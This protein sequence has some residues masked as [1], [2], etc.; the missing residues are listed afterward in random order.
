[1]GPILGVEGWF[2]S[3]RFVFWGSAHTIRAPQYSA[4]FGSTVLLYRPYIRRW[5]VISFKFIRICGLEALLTIC[6]HCNT[7]QH[8]ATH[9]N[10]LPNAATHCHALQHTATLSSGCTLFCWKSFRALFYKTRGTKVGED[11]IWTHPFAVRGCFSSTDRRGR[12]VV[13]IDNHMNDL[14]QPKEKDLPPPRA[15]VPRFG[16]QSPRTSVSPKLPWGLN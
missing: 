15:N 6:Q 5:R 14:F 4:L 11:F 2:L 12:L 8:T 3:T 7:L 13:W 10:T 1:M 16:N 9:C